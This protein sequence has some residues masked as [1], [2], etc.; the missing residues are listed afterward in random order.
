[1]LRRPE[2]RFFTRLDKS[3]VG[4]Q[5]ASFWAWSFQVLIL[6]GLTCWA[7]FDKR[8]E[9]T[10]ASTWG[11][12]SGLVS[13]DASVEILSASDNSLR[14]AVLLGTFA[15]ALGHLLWLLS[16][17]FIGRHAMRGLSSWL[18]LMLVAMFWFALAIH[19]SNLAWF[20]KHLRMTQQ[21][22]SLEWLAE[23]IR[24]NWPT[25]DGD[26]ERLGPY[27]A[28]P[29]GRPTVLLMLT[30][31]SLWENDIRISSIVRTEPGSV[32]FQLSGVEGDVW[33]EW[34]PDGETP[35]SFRTGLGEHLKLD[36]YSQ[37]S[38]HWYLARYR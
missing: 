19:V 25:Q 28:Y 20:G 17:L 38:E 18:A 33:A 24:S 15:A 8:F 3:G 16:S 11:W 7:I 13:G 29:V 26:S 37:M 2:R 23:P 27:M 5:S 10:L 32:R 14:I 34:H 1:M 36:R 9:A 6:A 22:E 31:P 21:V 4:K 12:M 30:P 35:N